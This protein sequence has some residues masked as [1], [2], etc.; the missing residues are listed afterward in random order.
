MGGMS[1]AVSVCIS[2]GTFPV[3]RASADDACGSPGWHMWRSWD[4]AHPP[5]IPTNPLVEAWM[6]PM[7]V[8]L[9]FVYDA[10]AE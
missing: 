3:S 8:Q 6:S 7:V 1:V 10:F 9:G 4:G 2:S 5:H